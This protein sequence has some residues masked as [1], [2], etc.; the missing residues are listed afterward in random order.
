MFYGSIIFIF[1]MID[2]IFYSNKFIA[3]IKL[4]FWKVYLYDVFLTTFGYRC[5][6][7]VGYFPCLVWVYSVSTFGKLNPCKGG[8]DPAQMANEHGSSLRDV[9]YFK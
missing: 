4:R 8:T 1:M 5:E 2:L 6:C 7:Y 3:P 9:V